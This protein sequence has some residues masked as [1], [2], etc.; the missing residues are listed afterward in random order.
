MDSLFAFTPDFIA[1][2]VQVIMID[3]VLAGDNAVV[4][5]LAAAGLPPE[6]RS[7]AILVA[8]SPPPFCELLLPVL[9]SSCWK[10]SAF[11]WPAASCCFGSVGKCGVNCA[12]RAT[13]Q[14]RPPCPWWTAKRHT[15]H[16]RKR[17][18]KS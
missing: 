17:L 6:Q 4:I 13:R 8:S 3:L 9:R 2:L 14:R 12:A 11:F 1:A 16:S 5:G 10:S 18:G 15:K 7:R